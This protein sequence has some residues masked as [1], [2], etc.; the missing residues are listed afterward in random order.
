MTTSKISAIL[1][2]LSDGKWHTVEEIQNRVKVHGNHIQRVVEFL[3]TYELI[4]I[5]DLE[6]KIKLS[7]M[8][9]KFLA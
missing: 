4:V 8:T 9:Q 1:D 3:K 6:K 7:K 2:V 5:D